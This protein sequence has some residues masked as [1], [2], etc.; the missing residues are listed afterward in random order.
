MYSNLFYI[1]NFNVIGGVETY[2]YEIAKK[3][4]KYDITVLYRQGDKEQL[5]RL[6]KL[7]R[8]VKY[9]GQPIKCKRVFF[10]Y[11]IDLID[12]IEADEYIQVI[13]AMYISNKLTPHTHPKL[14]KYLAVSE[15]AGKEWEELTGIKPDICRN[16]LEITEEEK[17]EPILLISATRLTDEKGAW[18]MQKIAN[19]MDQEKIN[20]LWLIF[21]DSPN[22][23][24]SP[25]IV[26]LKPR[27]D[28][29]PYIKMIAGKGYGVQLSDCEGDCY[30]T[31]EC[32]AFG[33]PLIC[34]PIPSFKEQGLVDSKNCYYVPF[35]MEGIDVK[36]F[37]KI[38]TYKGYV[39][40]DTWNEWL[41][42]EPSTY[43]EER[44]MKVK[45]KC[46]VPFVDKYTGFN[47]E[48][49]K[50]YIITKERMEEI[51]EVDE[52]VELVEEIKEEVIAPK[53]EKNDAI[54]TTFDAIKT[55]KKARK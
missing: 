31:R 47:Y 1:P 14:T 20:Y 34:T 9:T 11:T 19:L 49:G 16:V 24:S 23:I 32:E 17:Q 18:R 48:E 15:G 53:K 36:R 7:V 29:R 27:L 55:K 25:N 21:T 43:K 46:L 42:N 37:L 26:Y 51:L 50:E 41:I 4:N 52:L 8:V 45:V 38:P 44:D 35:N 28:I 33:V 30:F 13:H 39:G 3:Y 10:N 5:K 12:E 22:K 40:K 2:I 6:K 54:K